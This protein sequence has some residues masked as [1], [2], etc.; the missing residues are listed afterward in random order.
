MMCKLHLQG[1][2]SCRP[3]EGVS[4]GIAGHELAQ[5]KKYIFRDLQDVFVQ[6]NKAGIAVQQ[7]KVLQ[8]LRQPE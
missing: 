8:R 4:L 1:L 6:A 7:I 2:Y 5:F 3:L